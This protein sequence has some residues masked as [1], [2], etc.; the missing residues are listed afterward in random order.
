[1]LADKLA[2]ASWDFSPLMLGRNALSLP[3]FHPQPPLFSL[4]AVSSE[5]FAADDRY[6]LFAQQI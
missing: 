6:R 5:V 3:A 2:I 4:Q 1:M